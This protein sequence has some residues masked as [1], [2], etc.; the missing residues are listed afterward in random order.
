M[1]TETNSYTLN[2]IP[3]DRRLVD[4]LYSHG[5]ISSEAR[6]YALNLLCPHNQWGLWISRLQ[7]T[8]SGGISESGKG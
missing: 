5:K 3:A 7:K 8:L 6:E 1:D 2:Q 4:Q